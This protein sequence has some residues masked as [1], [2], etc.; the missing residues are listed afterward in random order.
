[1]PGPI[2]DVTVLDLSSG[3]AGSLC[4]ML[5][6]DNGASVLKV[7][8]PG[9]DPLA[10]GAAFR[11]WLRGKKS[12]TLDLE[13]QEGKD[14][15]FR[16]LP[17]ADVLF[18]TYQPGV[19][20]RM[21]IDYETLKQRAPHLV[22]CSLTPYGQDSADKDRPA[23]D[24]L[25]QAQMGLQTTQP[26]HRPPPIYMGFAFPS[27]SGAYSASYGILGALHARTVTGRGQFV[28]A[29]LRGGSI[30][31]NRW[32]W[33]AIPPE[34]GGAP[35]GEGGLTRAWQCSDG[36]LWTHTGARGSYER[37][38]GA[39]GLADKL[40]KEV[41]AASRMDQTMTPAQRSQLLKDVEAVMAS[42]KRQEIMGLMDDADVP[43]R[44]V[45][46]AGEAFNDEQVKAIGGVVT[47][48]DPELGDLREVAPPFD[49]EKTRPTTPATAPKLGIHTA[50]ILGR[51]GYTA[52]DIQGLRFRGV[53]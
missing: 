15:L 19:A 53:I 45:L 13:T 4:T 10:K 21:G 49:F 41:L 47:V 31:M 7:D 26:G 18:E 37:M 27:F 29:S 36:L 12:V 44:P 22:Y 33:A 2:A 34:E 43:N 52:E 24:G 39:L 16:L 46:R 17:T 23:Y 42:H 1:M 5:L 28:D 14:I 9:G 48:A 11:V 20:K 35:R 40:P 38:L 25:V 32:G 8:P 3:M 6:A 50:E 51:A 30:V